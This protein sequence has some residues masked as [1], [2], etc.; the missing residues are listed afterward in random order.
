MVVDDLVMS[1][2]NL[3]L[4]ETLA[5][6]NSEPDSQEQSGTGV[7]DLDVVEGA[8]EGGSSGGLYISGLL[9]EEVVQEARSL[10][11]IPWN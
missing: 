9:A 6:R 3:H 5:C 10:E 7:L 8:R 4:Q 2:T 11:G 1:A